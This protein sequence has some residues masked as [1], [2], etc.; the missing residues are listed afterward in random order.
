[1]TSDKQEIAFT[2]SLVLLVMVSCVIG[3]LIEYRLDQITKA[4]QQQTQK[5]MLGDDR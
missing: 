5:C 4:I 2:A 1:M 3:L